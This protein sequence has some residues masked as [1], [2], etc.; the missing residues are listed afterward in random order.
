MAQGLLDR[1]ALDARAGGGRRRRPCATSRPCPTRWGRSCAARRWPTGC[2]S[3]RFGCPMGVVGMVYEARPNVTVDAA[4]LGLKSGNAVILRG[5]SAAESTNR[6]L[7]DVLRDALA[8]SGLPAERSRCSRDG[9]D[10]VR[11]LL[12][13]RGLVDL[14][15][16]R[17][18][19]GPDP[20]RRPRVHRSGHR[21]R[22]SATATSTSTPPPTSTRRSRSPST[23]RPSAPASATRPSRCWSTRPSPRDFLPK[24]LAEL[25]RCRCRAAHRDASAC[26]PPSPPGCRTRPATDEDCDTEYLALEHER[27]G[28]AG[29]RRRHGPHPRARLGAHRGHRHRGPGRGPPVHQRGRRGRRSWSTPRPGSPTAA[30]SA[31]APRSASRPRSCTP[32]G[33]WRCRS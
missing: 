29:P 22:R 6:A 4:G 19:A 9:R 3:G 1:L 14:I 2:R 21:D 12:T 5:G 8:A 10:A 15:I 23:P 18:G 24:V 28:R 33:R 20:D 11:A 32:A 25:S 7:V 30:S 16:P 31:S 17:G 26:V 27:A 13:A